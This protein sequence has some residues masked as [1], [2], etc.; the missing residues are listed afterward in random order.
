MQLL[1]ASACHA[2][3]W[4]EH[5][6]ATPCELGCRCTRANVGRVTSEVDHGGAPYVPGDARAAHDGAHEVMVTADP[7]RHVGQ[8]HAQRIRRALQGC[9]AR[10]QR[11]ERNP[12]LLVL[13]TTLVVA[14]AQADDQATGRVLLERA[15]CGDHDGRW[16][17]RRAHHQRSDRDPSR[18]LREDR[19]QCEALECRPLRA[20]A[21][22]PEHV[23]VHE[24]HVE[25]VAI[26]VG[27]DRERH[28]R[29]TR[30]RRQRQTDA[31]TVDTHRSSAAAWAAAPI[32]PARSPSAA[33]TSRMS[34]RCAVPSR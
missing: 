15:N 10:L 14:R 4:R 25:P 6:Q 29:V 18:V 24:H 22:E 3:G 33:G 34:G 31:S 27:C 30:E 5:D 16:P 28:L 2:V 12:E 7:H 1:G 21:P 9:D 32:A 17:Q 23:V 13:R 26:G 19:E 20:V 11:R 8:L